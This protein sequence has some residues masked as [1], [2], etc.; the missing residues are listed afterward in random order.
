MVVQAVSR[1]EVDSF[2][3]LRM[4]ADD[5]LALPESHVRLELVDGVVIVS[6][7]PSYWHQKI[8]FEICR[9]IDDH[10]K[11][12][13]IGDFVQDIDVKLRDDLVYRPDVVFLSSAKAARVAER[14]I[15]P[16]DLVVEVVSP[17]SRSLDTQTKRADYQAAGVGE[18]WLIDPEQQSLRFFVLED[19]TYRE[20]SPAGDFYVSRVIDGLRLDVERIRR[21]F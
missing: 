15:E 9:Q 8:V 5:F 7:S 11:R 21:M 20:A 6:P 10:L 19:G 1:P 18:Y 12:H 17:G 13:P 14:I 4:G 3:G 16:P 2:L